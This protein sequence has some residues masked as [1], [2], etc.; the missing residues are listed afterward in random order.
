VQA[1][2]HRSTSRRG[3]HRADMDLGER[4][5]GALSSTEALGVD[6]PKH[7]EGTF[8]GP[9]D[10]ASCGGWT[11]PAIGVDHRDADRASGTAWVNTAS[12]SLLVSCE[13]GD[14]AGRERNVREPI[15]TVGKNSTGC[16]AAARPKI[17]K[18]DAAVRVAPGG[19]RPT[20][21]TGERGVRSGVHGCGS[22]R[23]TL[24]HRVDFVA[25]PPITSW[26][27]SRTGTTRRTI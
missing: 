4:P 13:A 15:P 22:P 25:K 20:R 18:A 24:I 5:A 11:R 12:S 7:V 1:S 8:R 26:W 9:F 2:L 10:R 23:R 19:A 16:D 21:F 6:L 3:L 17:D 27:V 14:H